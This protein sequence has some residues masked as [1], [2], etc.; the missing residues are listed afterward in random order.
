MINKK[1]EQPQKITLQ[2]YIESI[3]HIYIH[4]EHIVSATSFQT[5]SPPVTLWWLVALNFHALIEQH[6]AAQT[7]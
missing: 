5:I 2:P 6:N 4:I 7:I 3:D 1:K